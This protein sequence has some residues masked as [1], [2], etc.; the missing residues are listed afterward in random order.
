MAAWAASPG[1]VPPSVPAR[2][3]LQWRDTGG[4]EAELRCSLDSAASMEL[5]GPP[6]HPEL[7]MPG[8]DTHGTAQAGP[9]SS[10]A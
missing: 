10:L 5:S 3:M 1:Q 4:D 7:R 2:E 9:I 8:R 6:Q